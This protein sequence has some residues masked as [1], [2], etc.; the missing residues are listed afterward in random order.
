MPTAIKALLLYLVNRILACSSRFHRA[1]SATFGT[2]FPADFK[3]QQV[4]PT[5][6]EIP[7]IAGLPGTHLKDSSRPRG[8]RPAARHGRSRSGLCWPTH[9]VFAL[10]VAEGEG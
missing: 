8:V 9:A 5:F 2:M 4:R 10:R 3:E 7:I 1:S 6:S